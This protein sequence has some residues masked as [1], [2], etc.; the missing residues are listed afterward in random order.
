MRVCQVVTA[1]ALLPALTLTL[2]G[3]AADPPSWGALTPAASAPTREPAKGEPPSRAHDINGDGYQD[4]L[5]DAPDENG[6]TLIILYGSRHGLSPDA[7]TVV[8]G[9]TLELWSATPPATTADLDGD[10]FAD[11]VARGGVPGS[12]APYSLHVFWGGPSG[13]DGG[14]AP[15]ALRLPV[16]EERLRS[17]ATAGDFDGDGAADLA[18]S[19]DGANGM[20]GDLAVLYGPFTRAGAPARHTLR[21]SP[22]GGDFWRMTADAI[23]AGR[24]TGLLVNEADDGEQVP[25][26]LV[27]AGPG[28]LAERGRKLNAGVA[29]AWGDFDGDGTRDVVVADDGS[30]NNEPGFETEPPGVAGVLTVYFGGREAHVFRNLSGG[31]AVA[32][33]FDGDGHDDLAYGGG[34]YQKTSRGPVRV[35]WGGRDGLRLGGAAAGGANATPL[36][37]GDYDRDGRDEL[38]LGSGDGGELLRLRVTDGKRVSGEFDTADLL[39]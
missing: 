23:G 8:T 28:G 27:P 7:R 39:S 19:F 21:P 30:R 25:A 15:T 3:C 26:W 12:E 20:D 16:K 5:V 10:G 32:G 6:T 4:L 14:R 2:T 36:A 11:V 31:R 22:T 17:G 33:D 9:K 1:A 18:M 29:S 24:A 38:V 37:A 35:F 34:A 13:V